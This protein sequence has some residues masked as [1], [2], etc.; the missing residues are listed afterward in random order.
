MFEKYLPGSSFPISKDVAWCFKTPNPHDLISE[1]AMSRPDCRPAMLLT[2]EQRAAWFEP[3]RISS[4]LGQA[5]RVLNNCFLLSAEKFSL[6]IHGQKLNMRGDPVSKCFAHVQI[7]A[8]SVLVNYKLL[9][10][11]KEC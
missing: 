2:T 9:K 10:E 4:G 1:A 11:K 5:E 6:T 8:H 7:R 3:F